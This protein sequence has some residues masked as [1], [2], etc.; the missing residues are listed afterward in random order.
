VPGSL[1]VR[2]GHRRSEKRTPETDV[3]CSMSR[4][5]GLQERSRFRHPR[6]A[7]RGVGTGG[8][9]SPVGSGRRNRQPASVLSGVCIGW[10]KV[11]GSPDA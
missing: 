5:W 3:S 4:R 6:S 9:T 1:E 2:I 10:V 7:G 8:R 11:S